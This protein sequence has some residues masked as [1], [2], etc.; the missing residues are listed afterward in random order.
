MKKEL[1][2]KEFYKLKPTKSFW[3]ITSVILLFIVPEI[4][5]FVWGTDIKA[6]TDT[7]REAPLEFE[8]DYAYKLLGEL[9]EEGSWINLL[10]GVAILIW[11]FF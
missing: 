6:Y 4:I 5:A 3:G 8:Q 1:L 10:I 9:M 7:M 2:K 11:A